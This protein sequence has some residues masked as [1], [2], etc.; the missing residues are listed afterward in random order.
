MQ[1]QFAR[2]LQDVHSQCCPWLMAVLQVQANLE[3]EMG[4]PGHVAPQREH[5][6]LSVHDLGT[7]RSEEPSSV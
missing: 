6:P 2:Q 4:A 1:K 3:T 7:E 5:S